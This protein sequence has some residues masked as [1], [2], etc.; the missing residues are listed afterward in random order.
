MSG[1][2]H[3][4]DLIASQIK[5][6]GYESVSDF[7]R[8]HAYAK[9][10][11]KHIVSGKTKRPSQMT[12]NRIAVDLRMI[13]RELHTAAGI[14]AEHE[15][16]SAFGVD[17]GTQEAIIK[18]LRLA[19]GAD[20]D[21]ASFPL[22]VMF[23]RGMITD[24]EFFAGLRYA[25]LH[26]LLFGR[27]NPRA[28]LGTIAAAGDEADNDDGRQRRQFTADE[29]DQLRTL[30]DQEARE[31]V[32][33]LD[34]LFRDVLNPVVLEDKFPS[35]L[36]QEQDWNAPLPSGKSMRDITGKREAQYLTDLSMKEKPTEFHE[37]IM[38]PEAQALAVIIAGLNNCARVA[39]V[40]HAKRQRLIRG[41][42]VDEDE[43]NERNYQRAGSF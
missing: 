33:S 36:T 17:L 9:N 38:W 6:L 4:G 23:D 26:T 3:L 11:V 28:A 22:G 29:K 5:L 35:F 8:R 34:P 37:A 24:P 39:E 25:L 1:D 10:T 14:G 16:A 41:F 27:S 32:I 43:S 12:L 21:R 13:P 2:N 15:N 40:F 30:M 42:D 7:E 19:K 20:P 18:R 31:M